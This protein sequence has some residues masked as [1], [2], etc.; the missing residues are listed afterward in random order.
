M[1][2]SFFTL[3]LFHMIIIRTLR[4]NVKISFFSLKESAT[5]WEEAARIT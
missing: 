5:L 3:E 4:N 2:A 1:L